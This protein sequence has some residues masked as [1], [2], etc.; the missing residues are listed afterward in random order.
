MSLLLNR[1]SVLQ[2]R[3][4]VSVKDILLDGR[5]ITPSSPQLHRKP[6]EGVREILLYGR[7]GFTRQGA[8]LPP[9]MLYRA[10]KQAPT[11]LSRVTTAAAAVVLTGGYLVLASCAGSSDEGFKDGP[12][13]KELEA[14]AKAQKQGGLP[15]VGQP[16]ATP[17]STTTPPAAGT[18]PASSLPSVGAAP[19]PGSAAP[20]PAAG[21]AST[22][23]R[24]DIVGT[25]TGR[26]IPKPTAEQQKQ[27]LTRGL[28]GD[29]AHAQYT[30]EEIRQIGE[31]EAEPARP[32][33][34][35]AQTP[36]LPAPAVAANPTDAPVP[37]ATPST[38]VTSAPASQL[39]TPQPQVTPPPAP[40]PQVAA[41][42]PVPDP[43]PPPPAPPG[44]GLK[45]PPIVVEQT[46]NPPPPAVVADATQPTPPTAVDGQSQVILRPPPAP[47]SVGPRRGATSSSD[48]M[49]A[50]NVLQPETQM[51][52]ATPGVIPGSQ[53][54]QVQ[55]R[56]PAPY[57]AAPAPM[58]SQ[59]QPVMVQ[60]NAMPP[61]GPAVPYS[62]GGAQHLSS[63][64][65]EH[66]SA[67][68][69]PADQQL[70]AQVASGIRATG[71]RLR[72]VGHAS[73]RT[74]D[75]DIP[76]HN[77]ANYRISMARA[78]AIAAVLI[79]NGVPAQNILIE[80]QANGGA[81]FF[82]TMP[83]GEAGNRRADIFVD[84]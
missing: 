52:E 70:V 38:P 43:V 61:M 53:G 51:A 14:E 32:T 12:P 22:P 42:I 34:Q 54:G 59:S 73:S 60:P 18:A 72:I 41:E 9:V 4:G 83:S 30:D 6:L 7:P 2:G 46:T 67:S 33:R 65:F 17:A 39:P 44:T 25:P 40:A 23:V 63:I 57:A 82:E 24:P 16:P 5:M 21:T 56:P 80:A 35:A 26:S 62:F 74:S 37:P 19:P 81:L 1:Q 20:A 3:L 76:S 45:R 15:T 71:S 79:A 77:E 69:S 48:P 47:P 78:Q 75:M 66:G 50:P 55:L 29:K 58:Y 68:L 84:S 10:P 31:G 11:A 8:V 28:I 49:P 64:L 36:Q 13:P 27:A